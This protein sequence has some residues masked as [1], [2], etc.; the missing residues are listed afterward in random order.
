MRGRPTQGNALFGWSFASSL[1][2]NWTRPR[3]EMAPSPSADHGQ[4]GRPD[5]FPMSSSD[6]NASP[7]P[8]VLDLTVIDGL[9][10]LGGD[11][12]PQLLFELI[13]L[14]LEDA[15]ARLSEMELALAARDLEGMRRASH[16]LKS[17][18]ANMGA[19]LFTRLCQDLE[20][21]AREN[22]AQTFRALH[23]TSRAAYN[24]FEAALE[25]LRS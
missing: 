23:A 4:D 16:T 13:E 3:P 18:S 8:Q 17:S 11:E 14:F 2:E 9:R 21:A 12:D 10:E 5:R 19:V 7:D 15:P 1:P 22:D 20:S 24:E 25:Q 6:T